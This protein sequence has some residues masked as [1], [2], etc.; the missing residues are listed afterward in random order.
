MQTYFCTGLVIKKLKEGM[1][2]RISLPEGAKLGFPEWSFDDQWIAFNRYTDTGVELWVAETKTGKAKALTPPH[3]NATLND[4]FRWMPDSRLIINIVLEDRGEPPQAP[5]VPIGPNIQETSGKFAKVW[6]YQ[7]LLQNPYDE[8]LFDYY[9]TSQ[10][11]EIDVTTGQTRKIGEPGIYQSV[12]P[13]SDGNL[14]LVRRIKKPYSYSVPYFYFAHSYEIWEAKGKL[15]HLLADLPL[16]D[17]V[18]MRG[19][20]TGPRSVEWRPLKKSTLVWVEALDG[21][22]TSKKRD[23]LSLQNTT[24][25]KDGAPLISSI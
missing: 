1:T 24:G 3:I 20:P 18:P 4:G 8:A 13:S 16:A 19:V 23:W 5:A 14:L 21:G 12:S 11:V 15:V 2:L 7:D 10:I 25:R 17:E 22:S 9:T 6:T